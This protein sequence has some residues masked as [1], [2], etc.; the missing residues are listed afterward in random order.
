MLAK[1]RAQLRAKGI[2]KSQKKIWHH[3]CLL[4]R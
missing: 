4:Y 3:L 2:C 1:L